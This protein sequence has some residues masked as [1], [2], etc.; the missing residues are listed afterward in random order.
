MSFEEQ[1]SILKNRFE[2]SLLAGQVVELFVPD[3]K[4]ATHVITSNIHLQSF[5]ELYYFVVEYTDIRVGG[6]SS[7]MFN[8]SSFSGSTVIFKIISFILIQ[9]F[10]EMLDYKLKMALNK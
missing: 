8:I 4:A 5:F 3:L 6:R 1:L 2:T 9:I 10:I 7:D